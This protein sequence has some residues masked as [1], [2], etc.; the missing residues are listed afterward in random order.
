MRSATW[1][2]GMI[3]VGALAVGCGGDDGLAEEQLAEQA[4]AICVKFAQRGREL[5]RPDLAD[6]Q[7]AE[8]YFTRAADLARDQQEELEALE[9]ADEVRSDYEALTTATAKAIGLL[10]DL[11]AASAAADE[12][13]R[14]RLVNELPRLRV[15]VDEAA[16]A[17]GAQ[18]CAG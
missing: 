16:N 8:E 15:E 10:D 14:T 18:D 3:V 13:E 1:F 9:P 7:L 11:A 2:I 17:V 12:A 4:D 6:A 5:G